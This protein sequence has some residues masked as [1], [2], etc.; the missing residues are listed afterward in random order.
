M[1]PEQVLGESVDHR[2]DIFAFGSV[3]YEMASGQRPFKRD[4]SIATMAAIMNDEPTD[5][6]AAKPDLPAALVRIVCRCLEKQP[7]NRFQS[8]KD[9]AFAIE[10]TATVSTSARAP[11][12]AERT[13]ASWKHLLP[14][15]VAGLSILL[16]FGAVLYRRQGGSSFVAA[17]NSVA[18][19]SMPLLKVEIRVPASAKPGK[20]PALKGLAISPDGQKLAYLNDEGLWWRWLDRVGP[21]TLLASGE[22][23]AGPFWSPDSTDVGES[24]RELERPGRPAARLRPR[25]FPRAPTAFSW[26]VEIV[27]TRN[28]GGMDRKSYT[29][30][31]TGGR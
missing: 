2:A 13:R 11:L 6:T 14:W 15:A 29:S 10:S 30:P 21:A 28:G 9:L 5:L 1:A 25:R 20:L 26:P 18:V 31:G 17:S 4:T 19:S 3:L 22:K 8:A 27:S 12:R 24:I 7:D 16:A 23:L